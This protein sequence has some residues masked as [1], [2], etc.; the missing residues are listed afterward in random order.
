MSKTSLVGEGL[1]D[2][3][4][5][6]WLQTTITRQL[7]ILVTTLAPKQGSADYKKIKISFSVI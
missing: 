5:L 2:R 4:R 3:F 6:R 7:E 1:H